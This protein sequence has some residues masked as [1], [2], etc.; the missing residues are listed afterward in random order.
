LAGSWHPWKTS[1]GTSRR[2]LRRFATQ[3]S[4][5]LIHRPSMGLSFV[6]PRRAESCRTHDWAG[7]VGPGASCTIR[8]NHLRLR[9]HSHSS[10]AAGTEDEDGPVGSAGVTAAAGGSGLAR[11][12]RRLSSSK[13]RCRRQAAA[14]AARTASRIRLLAHSGTRVLKGEVGAELPALL[15][16]GGPA[17]RQTRTGESWPPRWRRRGEAHAHGVAQ[18][19]VGGQKPARLLQVVGE[20]V[21]PGLSLGPGMREDVGVLYDLQCRPEGVGDGV[22]CLLDITRTSRRWCSCRTQCTVTH[23]SA[24]DSHHG[25]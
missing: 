8:E 7:P 10:P 14:P 11:S 13:P 22:L 21:R 12:A 20:D 19:A 6:S 16:R 17:G 2:F 24:G 1:A 3:E 23:E 15:G 4:V 25:H 5:W 18:A 9:R